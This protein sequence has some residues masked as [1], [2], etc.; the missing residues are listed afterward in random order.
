MALIIE[1]HHMTSYP[2]LER[3]RD[4]VCGLYEAGMLSREHFDKINE[5]L[6]SLHPS[7]AD[8]AYAN[9]QAQR[10]QGTTIW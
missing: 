2:E 4:F 3:R 10:A 6:V 1:A 5:S 7:V 9:L 8:A